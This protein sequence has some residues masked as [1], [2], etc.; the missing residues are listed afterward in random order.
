[1]VCGIKSIRIC[2]NPL[3]APLE[4]PKYLKRKKWD[5]DLARIVNVRDTDGKLIY[6]QYDDEKIDDVWD[7]PFMG[8]TSPE[9]VG[10]PTQKPE[11]VIDQV[12]RASCNPGDIVLDCFAGSGTTLAVAE[13]LDRRWIGIDLNK[14]AIYTIQKR[15]FNLKREIGNKGKPLPHKPFTLYNAG[16]YDFSQLRQLPWNDWRFFALQLFGC[17]DEPHRVGGMKMDG[18]LKGSSVLVFDHI[19]HPNQRIDEDTIQ[20]IHL[21]IGKQVGRRM[22]IIAPRGVF[23]FQQDFVSFDDVQYFALRIPYSIISELHHKDFTALRQPED[24]MAVND[25]VDVVGFDFIR[26]PQVEYQISI[27]RRDG[28]LLDEVRLCI[29]QFESRAYLRGTD[30]KGGMDTLSM[31][32]FDYDYDDAIFDLDS[33]TFAHDLEKNTGAFGCRMSKWASE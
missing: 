3:T 23:D 29:K 15:M 21:E 20:D 6:D 7:I 14:L 8:A 25:T 4:R 19:A 24:E 12:I 11:S 5:K 13:K 1:M 2:F 18:K 33:V 31:V 27:A 32:M 10:Y 9:R 26:Q 17:K 16:L 28:Q 30:T 22:Y